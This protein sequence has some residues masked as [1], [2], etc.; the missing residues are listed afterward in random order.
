MMQRYTIDNAALFEEIRAMLEQGFDARFVV[1]GNSMWPTLAHSR[2]EVA[3]SPCDN[4][5][6]GDIVLLCPIEGRYVLHRVCKVRQN[7]VYT[8]GDGNCHRDGDFP[9]ACVLGRVTTLYRAGKEIAA[10]R[11][12]YRLYSHLWLLLYPLRPLLLKCL[13]RMARR[14]GGSHG[15]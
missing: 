5:K 12:L 10:T 1:T 14:R 9:T 8:C 4:V 13:R 15:H 2:D 3:V 11:G 7:R 6:R